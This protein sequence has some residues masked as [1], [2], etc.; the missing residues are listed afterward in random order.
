M[1]PIRRAGELERKGHLI[2]ADEVWGA[3]GLCSLAW[4]R[5]YPRGELDLK[6]FA[7]NIRTFGSISL[8][9]PFRV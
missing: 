4:R 9:S 3:K 8:P 5:I 7:E 2:P 1:L 6:K